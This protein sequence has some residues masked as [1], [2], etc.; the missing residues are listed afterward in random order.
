[1]TKKIQ[2]RKYFS[3]LFSVVNQQLTLREKYPTTE[4]FLVCIFLYSDWIRRFTPYSVRIQEDTDEKKPRIWTLFT[5]C[6]HRSFWHFNM[7]RMTSLNFYFRSKMVQHK[8]RDCVMYWMLRNTQVCIPF[9][10]WMY[11]ALWSNT[12]L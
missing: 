8:S 5:Q 3:L 12:S 2:F 9:L 4:L 7:I 1:M 10:T 11:I 6:N